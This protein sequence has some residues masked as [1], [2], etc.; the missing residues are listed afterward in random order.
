MQGGA[1]KGKVSER[2][3]N[4]GVQYDLRR[5]SKEKKGK[6]Y[7]GGDLDSTCSDVQA[8]SANTLN[9]V[10]ISKSEN[11]AKSSIVIALLTEESS[12]GENGKKLDMILNEIWKL[13]SKLP[14]KIKPRKQA[15]ELS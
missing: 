10:S 5:T 8:N 3:K 6:G 15:N 14:D 11:S 4:V 12:A 9:I 7:N 1:Q 2:S 13:N